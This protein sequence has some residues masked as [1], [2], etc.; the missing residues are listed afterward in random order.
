MR[1]KEFFSPK[2]WVS[3]ILIVGSLIMIKLSANVLFGCLGASCYPR[4]VP[5]AYLGYA[6]F[7]LIW[8]YLLI[9]LVVFIV[10]EVRKQK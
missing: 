7:P 10:G 3:L 5:L 8:L 4:L 6:L 9:S 2:W 1:L